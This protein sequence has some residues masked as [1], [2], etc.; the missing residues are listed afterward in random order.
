[1]VR[2]SSSTVDPVSDTS[3][4]VIIFYDYFLTIDD[5]VERFWDRRPSMPTV[6]FFMNRY[7]PLLSIVPAALQE[8]LFGLSHDV[9]MLH[10]SIL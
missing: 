6:L 9:R 4:L 8:G 7:L 5:E 1:M 3:F 10:T 2:P